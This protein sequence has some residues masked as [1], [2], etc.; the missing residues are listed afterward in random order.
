MH[1]AQQ[2]VEPDTV[3]VPKEDLL[4]FTFQKLY[5]RL[6]ETS[7]LVRPSDNSIALQHSMSLYWTPSD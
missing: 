7:A 4:L 5:N 2:P 1:G 6:W 3:T